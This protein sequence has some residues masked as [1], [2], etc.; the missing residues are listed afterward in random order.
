MC[1]STSALAST[2][3][4]STSVQASQAATDDRLTQ[5]QC[6]QR[7]DYCDV[8]DDFIYSVDSTG[9]V[10]DVMKSVAES[11]VTVATW[12]EHDRGTVAVDSVFHHCWLLPPLSV[13]TPTLRKDQT[14][15]CGSIKS[16]SLPPGCVVTRAGRGEPLFVMEGDS[17]KQ[18]EDTKQDSPNS[19]S[20][21][22]CY[23]AKLRATEL[24]ADIASTVLQTAWVQ[25]GP[26]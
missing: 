18:R 7:K 9:T 23:T 6:D 21:C 13:A 22:D 12:A 4:L 14:C 17:R 8:G 25:Y 3:A 26:N 1:T 2:S 20:V 24:S 19:L 10:S 15:C 16:S 11:F 5:L